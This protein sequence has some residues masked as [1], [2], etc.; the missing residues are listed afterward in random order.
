M[1]T[2]GFTLMEL[3]VAFAVAGIV[4]S[5][6]LGAFDFFHKNVTSVSQNYQ[7]FLTSEIRKLQ[8]RTA[9]IRCLKPCKIV[10]NESSCI[11]QKRF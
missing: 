3:L 6:S 8:C 4:A 5:V 9:E 1:N 2:K 10:G 7:R 11:C